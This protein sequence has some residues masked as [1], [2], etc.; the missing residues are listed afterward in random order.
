MS[1]YVLLGV[2]MVE[3]ALKVVESLFHIRGLPLG[4]SPLSEL[5]AIVAIGLVLD[6]WS[7]FKRSRYEGVAGAGDRRRGKVDRR[8]GRGGGRRASDSPVPA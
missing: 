8:S 3:P 7:K 6:E 2:G 4:G 5:G 1:R